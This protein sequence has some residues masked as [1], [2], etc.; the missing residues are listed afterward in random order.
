MGVTTR[1]LEAQLDAIAPLMEPVRRALYLEVAAS[2]VPIGRD[3]AAAAVGISRALAAFHLDRLADAGLLEV[4]F[5]RLSGRTGPG[6]GRPSKLYRSAG[7]PIELSIPARRYDDLAELLARGLEM[8]AEEVEPI[9]D[10]SPVA[11]LAGWSNLDPAVVAAV[12]TAAASFGRALAGEAREHAGRR[13]GRSRL[14]QEL[15]VVLDEHGFEP[16]SVPDGRII[17]RNCPFDALARAH[18]ALVCGLNGAIM[19]GALAEL[20]DTGLNA[21]LEPADGRCCVLLRPS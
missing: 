16:L 5:R 4:E 13:P 19:G 8:S 10:G 17:L 3:A 1:A 20:S 11:G 6:A 7:R 9:P 2:A 12:E 21:V 14:V 15:K 18:R